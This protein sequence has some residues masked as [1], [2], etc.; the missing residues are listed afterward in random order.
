MRISAR[1]FYQEICFRPPFGALPNPATCLPARF[2]DRRTFSP[3]ALMASSHSE[4]LFE[5]EAGAESEQACQNHNSISF[6]HGRSP[7]AAT[8]ECQVG[9]ICSHFGRPLVF[10]MWLLLLAGWTMLRYA[11]ACSICDS[12]N[13]R[14]QPLAPCWREEGRIP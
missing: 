1:A 3:A 5:S 6:R 14:R 12:I 11:H 10:H 7:L 8:F 9:P 4:S 2:V 13:L